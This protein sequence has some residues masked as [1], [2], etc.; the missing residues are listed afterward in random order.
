MRL[1]RSTL[2]KGL[3]PFGALKLLYWDSGGSSGTIRSTWRVQCKVVL[4]GS[5]EFNTGIVD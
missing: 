4:Q 2:R 3:C 1:S 5:Q